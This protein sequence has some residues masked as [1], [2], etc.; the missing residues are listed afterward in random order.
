MEGDVK[1]RRYRSERRRE[2]AEQTRQRVVAAAAATFGERG[3]EGTSISA[4]AERAGVSQ[5]T[6]YGRFGNKRALLG[7][8]LQ[9]AVRG[10]DPRPVPEQDGPRAVM[11]ATDLDERL[12]LFATDISARLERAAPLVAAVSAASR[13]EPELAELLRR[14][15]A[16]RLAN[17]AVFASGDALETVWAVTSPELYELLRRQRG[18]SQKR[19]RAWLVETLA[20][21]LRP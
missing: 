1:P 5:E 15:H 2:Q 21:T 19:Y 7:E 10:D 17:L 20:L 3:W 11:E 18:W 14:L 6:V 13:S 8:A 16:D 9:R 4:I 12:H